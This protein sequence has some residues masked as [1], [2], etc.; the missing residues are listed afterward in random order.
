MRDKIR[1][2]FNSTIKSIGNNF[3]ELFVKIVSTYSSN[4]DVPCINYNTLAQCI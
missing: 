3:K 1:L 2:I 4:I